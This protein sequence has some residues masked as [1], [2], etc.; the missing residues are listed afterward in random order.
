M[1]TTRPRV[2]IA[3]PDRLESGIIADWISP[4]GFEPVR[5]STV[6]SAV[7]E[8]QTRYFDLLI[9][10]DVFALQQ[11]L[12]AV[13]RGR[14]PQTPTVV[15]GD[16]ASA[17]QS[18]AINSQI[19][20]LPRP[21]EQALLVCTVS[22]A[23]ADGRPLRRSVRKAAHRFNAIVNGVPSHIIDISNEGLRLEMPAGRR[24]ILPPYFNAQVPLIGVAVT[25]QRMWARTWPG[26][27]SPVTLCGAALT[28]NPV[29]AARA[30][31]SFV[32]TIPIVGAVAA[33]RR[34]T[35]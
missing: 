3:S 18:E 7:E 16:T 29:R 24:S 9:A 20:Y 35:K 10:D 13:G 6:S 31:E 14:R 21:L 34:P 25:V 17:T 5:R 26:Q 15:L 32:D 22:M 12:H 23:V 27:G 30:W 11:G 19:M 4:E 2:V 33:T 1:A 8:I 28:H